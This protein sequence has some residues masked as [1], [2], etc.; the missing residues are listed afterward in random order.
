MLAKTFLRPSAGRGQIPKRVRMSDGVVGGL[1]VVEEAA[2]DN[3]G[4]G[5]RDL[6]NTPDASARR[7]KVWFVMSSH[8]KM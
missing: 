5:G 6:T 4:A 8:Q 7:K 1:G 2:D 3:G